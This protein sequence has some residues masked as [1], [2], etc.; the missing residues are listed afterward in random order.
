MNVN[1]SIKHTR[2]ICFRTKKWWDSTTN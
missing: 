2:K 1:C